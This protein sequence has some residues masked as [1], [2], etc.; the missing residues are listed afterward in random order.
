MAFDPPYINVAYEFISHLQPHLLFQAMQGDTEREL[1]LK[2]TPQ[3]VSNI[4]H[5]SPDNNSAV[6]SGAAQ[7]ITLLEKLKL[8]SETWFDPQGSIPN[9]YVL[10]SLNI[11]TVEGL[12]PTARFR[13][14]NWQCRI[15]KPLWVHVE[16]A[17]FQYDL[18][19][20]K[21]D[22]NM[23]TFLS[24]QQRGQHRIELEQIVKHHP[25]FFFRQ[26]KNAT[27]LPSF[28]KG[29]EDKD[30]RVSDICL[31][32][33][34]GFYFVMKAPNSDSFVL[35]H[36][37][38]D[39]TQF[40][41]SHA[42]IFTEKELRLELEIEAKG[43]I[44]A[45]DQDIT[46]DDQDVLV[47]SIFDVIRQIST[48]LGMSDFTLSKLEHSSQSVGE[49]Y[50]AHAYSQKAFKDHL[51]RNMDLSLPNTP[52]LQQLWALAT[53]KRVKEIIYDLRDNG[54][55]ANLARLAREMPD[56]RNMLD[57]STGARHLI[58]A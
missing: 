55:N 5:L 47:N 37:T 34:T 49:H 23:K 22:A 16:T 44:G 26:F 56:P 32:S 48:P 28:T 30:L 20:R 38:Y 58:V 46:S 50:R 9:D 27:E 52:S 51:E 24:G 7:V 18:M 35:F 1:K 8:Q 17:N 40:T 21:I 54:H 53:G 2:I 10:A 36:A 31:T 29:I 25:S 12:V 11:D 13:R 45:K 4:I 19:L 15:R 6:K 3:P 33:R 42:D 41:T 14:E 57:L 39:A 43:V